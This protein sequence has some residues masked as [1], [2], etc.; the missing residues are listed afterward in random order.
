VLIATSALHPDLPGMADELRAFY[1]GHGEPDWSDRDAVIDHIVAEDR[2]LAGAAP[3]DEAAS[4]A[5]V[6]RAVDRSIDVA[7]AGN[8]GRVEGSGLWWQRLGE[9]RVPTLVVHGAADPLFPL[10]HGEALARDIPGAS[11][12]R[13]DQAGHGLPPRSAWDVL[14]PA[15]LALR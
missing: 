1:A 14:V 10:P 15:I 2:A 12:L 8:H 11:L 6:T 3:F 5:V 4:R 13:I 9:I 7:A